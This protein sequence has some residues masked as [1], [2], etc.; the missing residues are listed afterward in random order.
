MRALGAGGRYHGELCGLTRLEVRLRAPKHS[1]TYL[2]SNSILERTAKS[3]DF[4]QTINSCNDR[5]GVM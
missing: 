3:T 2:R 1:N 4:C 5:K